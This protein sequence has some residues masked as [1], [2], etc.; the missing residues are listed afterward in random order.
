MSAMTTKRVIP[1]LDVHGGQVTRGVRFGRAEEGGLRAVGDPVE[2]ARRYDE[3]GADEMVFF[4][5]T[6]TA[7]GRAA[8]IGVI[9]RV[10]SHCFMPLTVGGGIRTVSDMEAMLR[11]GADKTSINSS[12]LA[13]P[14]LISAGAERFGSQCI[15]VSIDARKTGP[16]RWEVFAAGGRQAT[17][18]DAVEWAVES[19]ARGAGEIVLNSID[20]DGTKAG[21]DLTI[22]RRI[23]ESV[24]VPVVASGGAGTLEH[25]A[26]VLEEGKADAVLAASV[27][28]FGE[29][30][31]ADVKTYLAGRGIAVRPPGR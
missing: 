2:L 23:S 7:E 17:G 14:G 16:D 29:V 28:H 10:A 25:M 6:A 8:M 13:D 1:C 18:R 27:F 22:T 20:A 15:V 12:A 5:I 31:V 9:E 11:A 21:Y 30:T 19:A 4:D 26:E 3:Q 24:G